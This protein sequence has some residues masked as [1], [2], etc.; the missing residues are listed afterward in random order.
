MKGAVVDRGI[1]VVEDLLRKWADYMRRDESVTE[2]YPE[3]ASG[4]FIES[5]V[6]DDEE[7]TDAADQ[8]ELESINASVDSLSFM[9]K[10]VVYQFQGLGYQVWRFANAEALYSAAKEDFKRIHF[11]KAR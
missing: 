9:H 3:K 10:R 8:R 11:C 1:D 7:L 5:W 2:G 4:G 6:K